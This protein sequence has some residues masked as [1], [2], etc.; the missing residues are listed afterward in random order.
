MQIIDDFLDPDT[1]N[2]LRTYMMSSKMPWFYNPYVTRKEDTK[3]LNEFQFTHMFLSFRQGPSPIYKRIMPLLDK[4]NPLR[5][6]RVKANLNTRTNEIETRD[7]HTDVIGTE[8]LTSIYYLN[9]NNGYTSFESG[10]TVPSKANRLL[11]FN[12]NQRHTGTT[13]TDEK[14]RVV[15][16]INYYSKPTISIK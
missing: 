7:F 5:T 2:T 6:I 16:N 11:T 1:F 13:C 10:C 15:I 9:T 4:I 14:V 12:S 3:H 8:S